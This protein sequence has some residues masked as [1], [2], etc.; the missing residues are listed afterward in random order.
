[1]ISN[2]GV[3]GRRLGAEPAVHVEQRVLEAALRH[4]HVDAHGNARSFIWLTG[5]GSP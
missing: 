4:Q 2:S 1:M 3:Y 5:C